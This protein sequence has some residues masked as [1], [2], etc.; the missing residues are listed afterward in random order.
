MFLI[1]KM[2]TAYPNQI[3]F[4]KSAKAAVYTQ[5]KKTWA[6]LIQQRLRWAGKNKGLKNHVIKNVWSFVGLYH[7]LLVLTFATAVLALTPWK[8]F[9]ILLIGKWLADYFV[10]NNAAT[11]FKRT[12]LVRLF[13]T[14][15]I[16]YFY[17]IMRLSFAMLLGK[18]GD[19]RA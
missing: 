11:F 1:E 9:M 3:S 12:D 6:S 14:L 5:G 16:F 2:R 7:L 15:Q 19:W 18:K 4:L 10:I 13:V 17:Y 8:P